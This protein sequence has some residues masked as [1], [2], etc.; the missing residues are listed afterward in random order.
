MPIENLRGSRTAVVG[1]SSTN[2]YSRIIA[3]DPDR[4]PRNAFLGT[5][6]C[7]AP[8][9][10]SWFFDLVGPSAHVQTACSSSVVAL[11]MACQYIN[12]GDA[13]MV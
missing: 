8:N 11:D 2:D 4:A 13:S 5:S 12:S 10:I 9:R 3:K 6:T 1:V 7:L